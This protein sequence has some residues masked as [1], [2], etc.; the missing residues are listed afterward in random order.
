MEDGGWQKDA[1]VVKLQGPNP[2]TGEAQ[3][4]KK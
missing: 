2:K 4:Q 3:S 1:E